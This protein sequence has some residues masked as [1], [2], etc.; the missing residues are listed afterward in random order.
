MGVAVGPRA[1]PAP[2]LLVLVPGPS[3]EEALH[4][5]S[6]AAVVAPVWPPLSRR[7]V[8]SRKPGPV[9]DKGPV[10]ISSFVVEQPSTLTHCPRGRGPGCAKK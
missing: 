1:H 9:R 3:T 6:S 5:P 4:A 2:V 8:R 7:E 10:Y